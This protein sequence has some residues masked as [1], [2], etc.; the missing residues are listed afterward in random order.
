MSFQCIKGQMCANC[1]GNGHSSKG[2]RAI[3]ANMVSVTNRGGRIRVDPLEARCLCMA[4]GVQ[5]RFANGG[6]LLIY[7]LLSVI[8]YPQLQVVYAS[9]FDRTRISVTSYDS[10]FIL[11]N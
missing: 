8:I 4:L 6:G 1:T 10:M 2:L 7:F 5:L 3:I 9:E 11:S